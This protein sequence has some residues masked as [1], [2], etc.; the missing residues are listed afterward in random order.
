MKIGK[1]ERK[2]LAPALLYGWKIYTR[3]RGAWRW[4]DDETMPFLALESLQSLVRKGLMECCFDEYR[5]TAL[6]RTL[7]CSHCHQGKLYQDDEEIGA[8]THCDGTGVVLEATDQPPAKTPDPDS[9]VWQAGA[10]IRSI[11]SGMPDGGDKTALNRSLDALVDGI[12]YIEKGLVEWRCEARRNAGYAESARAT[13]RIAIGHLQ[14]MLN[15]ARNF[16]DQQDADTAAR[17]WLISIGSNP[18]DLT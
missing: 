11:A 7:R 13:A 15:K 2:A 10:S 1:R 12:D 3:G 4:D 6:A 14:A 8:C 9:D 16:K 5:A 18:G 17:D